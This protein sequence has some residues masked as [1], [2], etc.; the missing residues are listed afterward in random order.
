MNDLKKIEVEAKDIKAIN[1]KLFNYGIVLI[2]GFSDKDSIMNLKEIFNDHLAMQ[3]AGCIDIH[4]HPQN[5]GKVG[6]YLTNSISKD[7]IDLKDT[8][9]NDFTEQIAREYYSGSKV[10][11]CD[12]LF[13]THE[14]PSETDILPW[15]FDRQES[16]KFYLNLTDVDI[17]NGAFQYDIGSHREGH[18]IANQFLMKGTSVFQIP[19]DVPDEF[20]RNP[21]VVDASA[22]DMIIFDSAGFHKAGKIDE[23]KERMVIRGHTHPDPMPAFKSKIFS[24][25]WFIR[26]FLSFTSKLFSIQ[27]RRASEKLFK[28]LSRTRDL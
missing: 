18:L 17:T 16:L 7:S 22:G 2:K 10:K 12:E 3:R 9:I 24:A 6:R 4:K 23:G 5:N 19:N 11:L 13:L 8:F 15:H 28:K 14:L 27:A 1:S 21:V 26:K 25:D 20:L